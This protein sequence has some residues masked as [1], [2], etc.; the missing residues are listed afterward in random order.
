MM[1]RYR[2]RQQQ[3]FSIVSQQF[4]MTQYLALGRRCQLKDAPRSG[5]PQLNSNCDMV[6]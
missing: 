1:L 2:R 6:N 5:A 4:L 3:E